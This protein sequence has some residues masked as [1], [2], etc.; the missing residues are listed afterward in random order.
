MALCTPAVPERLVKLPWYLPCIGSRLTPACRALLSNYAKI[1]TAKQEAYIYHA[2]DSAFLTFPLGTIGEFWFLVL[3]LAEHPSYARLINR[4]KDAPDKNKP[5]LIDL[6]TCLGQDLRKLVYDGAASSQ[7][8]GIDKFP[9]FAD[10]GYSFFQDA[11]EMKDCFVTADVF[12]ADER[13]TLSM[14]KGTWDIV[15]S[16]MFLH[17]FD[18]DGQVAAVKKMFG[19]AEGKGSWI[20]GLIAADMEEQK[21]PILPPIVPEGVKMSRYVHN[22]ESLSRLFQDVSKELG[23]EVTIEM[24]Y[25]ED[26][27]SAY[28]HALQTSF[29]ATME[30]RLL[31]YMVE[32]V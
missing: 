5:I 16:S 26:V 30:A 3:G 24:S 6:G 19:L 28:T 2:R 32:I 22:K 21:V 15:T 8:L 23:I 4:L 17:S 27:E 25:Q 20:M 29:F 31:F 10:I 18:W 9:Q 14:S 7:L 12:V 11:E 13:D 1:P